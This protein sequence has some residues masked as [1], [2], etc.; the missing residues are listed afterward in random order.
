M[1]IYLELWLNRSFVIFCLIFK[2]RCN[3]RMVYNNYSKYDYSQ[4]RFFS[5]IYTFLT[6]AIKMNNNKI[7][8]YD[9]ISSNI[10]SEY[11]RALFNI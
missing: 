9:L 7:N 1:F 2:F 5:R 11:T 4:K 6:L 10:Y 3:L 8:Y